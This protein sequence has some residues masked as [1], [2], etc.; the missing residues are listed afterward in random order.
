MP[1]AAL[2]PLVLGATAAAAFPLYDPP[3]TAAPAPMCGP[4]YLLLLSA[5]SA[6]PSWPWRYCR[7]CPRALRSD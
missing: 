2:L 7:R 4:R 3:L 5:G 6:L 1:R